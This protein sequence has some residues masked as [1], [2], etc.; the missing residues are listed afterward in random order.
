MWTKCEIMYK[1]LNMWQRIIFTP[2]LYLY[3]LDRW[4]FIIIWSIFL[5]IEQMLG[6]IFWPD[7]TEPETVLFLT[8]I[9]LTVTSFPA[10]SFSH[11]W[12]PRRAL[13]R[14]NWS[15]SVS[16]KK[17]NVGWTLK[18]E[19]IRLRGLQGRKGEMKRG[20]CG[21]KNK[22]MTK[23]SGMV[24]MHGDEKGDTWRETDAGRQPERRKCLFLPVVGTEKSGMW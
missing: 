13:S 9:S 6:R 18:I 2:N 7:I 14:R 17:V 5:H 10:S 16:Y 20:G 21:K 11:L 8:F 22:R 1:L 24:D 4:T 12:P 15:S 19:R 3:G 23:E